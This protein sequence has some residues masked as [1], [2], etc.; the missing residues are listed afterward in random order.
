MEKAANADNGRRLDVF[1]QEYLDE[2]GVTRARIQ[3]WIRQGRATING[4]V[5][6]RPGTRLVPGQT[7]EITPEP[8][9][10]MLVPVDGPLSVLYADN[11][12][13]VI[14][15][16]A[17]L[18]VHPAPSVKETTLAHLAVHRFPTLR[19]QDDERPGIVHRLDKDTSGLMVLALTEASRHALTG[20]F[21]DRT[22]YK[23]YLAL[24]AGVPAPGGV[25]TAPVGRHP[26]I[27]TRMAVTEDGRL[28]ETRFRVLW[29]AQDKSASLVRVRILTGRTHQIRV[30]MAHIGHPVLGDAVYAK[31]SIGERA[32]R[33][34]LHAW[35]LRL[36]HPDSQKELFF[37][38]P[39]PADFMNVLEDL[40]GHRICLGL[41]GAVGSGKSSVRRFAAE[42][43]VPT[44]CADK[45]VAESYAPGGAGSA[46]LE[47]H[48]GRSF[49]S[50]DGGV[51]KAALLAAM[52][53]SDR[54][55]S[56]VERLVHPL[57]RESLAAFMAAPGPDL[58]LAEIPLL[59]EA[60]LSDVVDL[61]AVIFRPDAARHAHLRERGWDAERIQ[62]IDA[63]QW[64]QEKKL[65]AAHFVL[66]NSGSLADLQ[67]RTASLLR[68]AR[69]IA[70]RRT[71][72][73]MA[74]LTALF[75]HPDIMDESNLTHV[76]PAR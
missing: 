75:E 17:G 40:C 4:Q 30:H 68:A 29:S 8:S 66:D 37:S 33:Q 64:S 26:S 21:S 39:P 42:Q 57:V 13:A 36:S 35:Q 12:L 14:N 34:M 72:R 54:L 59:C 11:S 15:K 6:T 43:G 52:S 70:H 48:L 27:K 55:R 65:S 1:W 7:L 19:T 62:T 16:D 63:W 51:N 25:I 56:E 61:I 46:I 67:R 50:E 38:T 18:A 47:H 32:P 49:L 44:F 31:K 28:A 73:Q 74:R 3:S 41:T 58:R 5:C 9:K 10:T 22:V 2:E 71:K 24:V 60:E 20:M 69:N 53:A 45:T 23:E 76:T